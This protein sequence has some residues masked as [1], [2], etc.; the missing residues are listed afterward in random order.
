MA[1]VQNFPSQ[2]GTFYDN[3]W[4]S[5]HRQDDNSSFYN[6]G[7][8]NN[9]GSYYGFY[10]GMANVM[11][12]QNY[13]VPKNHWGPVYNGKHNQP[14]S[15]PSF[16]RRKFSESDSV[17]EGR[18]HYKFLSYDHALSN[19][20][21]LVPVSAEP[22]T[23]SQDYTSGKCDPS[24][25][26]DINDADFMSRDE[27]D[28][29]SPS[30]KDGIDV[31]HETR[32]RHSYCAFI[33]SLGMRLQL[34]QTTIGTAMVFCHRFFLR[35]SHASHDRFLI[36][37]AALFLAAKSEETQCPLDAVLT[38]SIEILHKQ[39]LTFQP[40]MLSTDWLERSRERVID[41]EQLIL[42]TLNFE[43]EVQ[44]PYDPLTSILK[45]LGLSQTLLVN[46]ALTLISEGLKSSLWLQ[47]KPR[48]IAAGAAYLAAKLLNMDIDCCRNIS[49]EF[50]TPRTILQEV[51]QQLLEVA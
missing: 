11:K 38:T 12:S 49:L 25:L 20:N 15:S 2:G 13:D 19:Y 4:P 7:A 50:Q 8:Y 46:L 36:G 1:F 17:N 29:C 45:K 43:L 30:R 26:Q 37:T 51:V 34:P 3:C 28:K 23:S 32:L 22:S 40:Y 16:K 27:I 39:D 48:D 44:H 9:N 24:Q 31:L 42:T 47:F 6:Y 33:Q 21:D 14:H 41:A 18:Y 10:D 5:F 35:R